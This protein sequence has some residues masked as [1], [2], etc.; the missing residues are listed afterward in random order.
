MKI[1]FHVYYSTRFGEELFLITEQSTG[2]KSIKREYAMQYLD[3]T[4]WQ[5][6]VDVQDLKAD[7]YRYYYEYRSHEGVVKTEWGQR[8]LDL[9]TIS[10]EQIEVYDYWNAAGAIENVFETQAFQVFVQPPKSARS[11]K[12]NKAYTHVFE[13]KAPL[14]SSDEVP[15]LLGQGETLH[16]WNSKEPVL[17]SSTPQGWSA[18]VDMSDAQFPLAY[19]YGI[20]NTR[21]KSF[22]GFE[23]GGNR[24]LHLPPVDA[25]GNMAKVVLHDGFARFPNTEWRGTGVA[26][27]VFSL[28]SKKG[29]GVGEFTD[30]PALADWGQSVGLKL[31]QL[32]PINDTSAEDTWVDSYPYSAISAFALHPLYLN[33]AA[34]AGKEHAAILKPYTKQKN[35][36]NK[37]EAV[38]YEAVLKVKWEILRKLYNKQ[39]SAFLTNPDFIRY[40][41]ENKHWLVSYAA[42]CYLRNQNGTADFNQWSSHKVYAEKAIEKLVSPKSDHYDEI[43]I[44]YFVQWHLHCQLQKAVDYVHSKGLALKGDIPIGIYRYSC[45]AWVAPELYNMDMQSGA[46][47]DD[48]AVNGQNWGFP[49]YNWERMKADD[50]AWWQQR[51]KQMGLYFDAFR[52]DHILGFFRIWSIPTHA[53]E[54]ILG[55]FV[56]AI[57]LTEKEIRESGI[58]FD[59]DR[60]CQPYINDQVLE[61]LF[62]SAT[63]AVREHFLDRTPD[64][65]HWSGKSQY[66]LKPAYDTQAKVA[67]YFQAGQQP[68]G[69]RKSKSKKAAPRFEEPVKQGLLSLIANVVLIDVTPEVAAER[70]YAF[71]I[72]MEQTA[73]F[74][75][76]PEEVKG[77][78]KALY[79]DYFFRRQDAFWQRE[80]MEKLPYLKAVTNM[81]VCGEDLGMVPDGVPEVMEALGILSL[82]VQ[83]MPKKTGI[84]FFN[85]QDAPYLSV[86]TPSTHDMSTIRGWWEEDQQQ[87]QQ[88]FSKMLGFEGGAPYFCEPWVNQRIVDQH[89]HSPAMWAIFQLQDLMGIDGALRRG[90]PHDER[91]NIPA[92]PKH[93]WRYRMHLTLEDLK[94]ES[95]FNEQLSGMIKASGRS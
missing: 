48:F 20:W 93:Y 59:A 28:R 7:A 45:D 24:L 12:R 17:M 29:F 79:V 11:S 35:A 40:F 46:P 9:N 34:V 31:I 30:L 74:D 87:S 69:S 52:I 8:E 95:R 16:N 39:K 67:A 84:Q 88:F 62:G 50:F 13:L 51:F 68:A 37:L 6:V 33:V 25:K 41:L 47:P 19:K 90:S 70:H 57:P 26:I 58:G 77:P 4:R 38:D 85:P 54:G 66:T 5:I 89:L 60:L 78:L 72:N 76:L 81:M 94:K 61:D 55:Y 14:L 92:N 56:P 71:R 65:G 1:H 73:S 32:L 21:T 83:R 75:F 42:F 91:I 43:A 36:L 3:D 53:V 44:H 27:P 15:C 80:A 82:E 49:T 23:Q 10:G 63:E 86:V 18:Q 22:E 2:K 64:G